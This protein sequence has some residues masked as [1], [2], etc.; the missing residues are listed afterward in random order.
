MLARSPRSTMRT[1]SSSF[2][3]A[4]KY[5]PGM[6]RTATRRR[7]APLG[8][9]H[10]RGDENRIGADGRGRG[11]VLAHRETLLSPVSAQARLLGVISL[12]FD[13]HDRLECPASL[14]VCQLAGVLW[15]ERLALVHLRD[16]LGDRPTSFVH[17]QS[18]ALPLCIRTE[19]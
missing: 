12:V 9:L 7:A 2:M 17:S 15:G 6:S 16:L 3:L 13:V 5:A 8:R 18:C 11:V 10:G 4:D 1:S 19:S 14:F